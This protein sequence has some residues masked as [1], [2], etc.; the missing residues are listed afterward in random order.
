[1]WNIFLSVHMLQSKDAAGCVAYYSICDK[2]Q[3]K[4]NNK[5]EGFF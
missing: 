2:I 3:N 5:E 4:C 1:M